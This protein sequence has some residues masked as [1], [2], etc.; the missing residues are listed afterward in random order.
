MIRMKR[1][2]CAAAAALMAA[3]AFAAVPVAKG[4]AEWTCLDAKHYL[5]GRILYPGDMRGRVAVVVVTDAANLKKTLV[6]YGMLQTLTDTTLKVVSWDTYWPKG[7]VVVLFSVA[8]G[9]GASAVAE[10]LKMKDL[11]PKDLERLRRDISVY[12]NATFNGAPVVAGG[13]PYVYVTAP[14][15]A[16]P[17]LAEK[18]DKKKTPANVKVAV[19]K[20]RKLLKPRKPYF[21]VVEEP[22]F[23]P[24]LAKSLETG[25][26]AFAQVLGQIQ[27]GVTSSNPDQAKESQLLLDAF[28]QRRSDLEFVINKCVYSCPHVA[29]AH[30]GELTQRWPSAKKDVEKATARI[31]SIS[32]SEKMGKLYVLIRKCSD[33]AFVPKNAAETKK[34]VAEL[35]AAKTYLERMK[36][37]KVQVLQNAAFAMVGEIDRLVEDLPTRTAK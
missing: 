35:K 16:E 28:D 29:Y 34:L 20:G 6:D 23:Y 5:S 14:G 27:K 15:A 1:A 8:G 19:A 25:K 10:F 7:D 2:A 26:P 12:D 11:D 24:Q 4:F 18:C 32:G 30:I 13:Y 33:P 36:N 3:S 31:K 37:S 21:G 17:L 22:Q 9:S